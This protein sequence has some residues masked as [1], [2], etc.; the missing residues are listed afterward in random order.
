[1]KNTAFDFGENWVAYSREAL[2]KEKVESARIDFKQLYSG[3]SFEGK[4]FLDIGF[5]QGLALLFAKEMGAIVTGCDINHKCKES[6]EITKQVVG[7]KGEITTII[8][9]ILSKETMNALRGDCNNKFDIVHSWGV[10]HHTGSMYK[11]LKDV[12]TLVENDGYIVLA[13]YNR[14]W[15]S[16][17]WRFIK[18]VYCYMP[19]MVQ[20]LLIAGLTP[21]I[22][23]SKFIVTGKNPLK[24]KR[25]MS[26]FHDVTDWIGG[27]PYEYASSEEI[28]SIMRSK[29]FTCVRTVLAE[30]PTGCN[31]FVFKRE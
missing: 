24:C 17:L 28:C 29:G 19:Q 6:L 25:G 15:S 3:I 20:K 12:T 26:F 30:V 13:I 7:Y 22:V 2:T 18:F 27:Y 1:V 10:L 5:G 23:A 11:S 16:P 14:H 8:G 4:R 31:Q 9:S 21:I